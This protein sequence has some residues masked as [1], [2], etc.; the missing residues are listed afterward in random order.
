MATLETML[1]VDEPHLKLSKMNIAESRVKF[2]SGFDKLCTWLSPS[3]STLELDLRHNG[4]AIY[5]SFYDRILRRKKKRKVALIQPGAH[6]DDWLASV[7]VH[8]CT[9]F[10]AIITPVLQVF[11]NGTWL[12]IK[13]MAIFILHHTSLCTV[14]DDDWLASVDVHNC[15][16]F[17]AIITPVLQVFRNGTWFCIKCMAIFILHHTYYLWKPNGHLASHPVS[18]TS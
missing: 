9:W 16:W 6:D 5:V 12:C 8:N 1:Q 10:I 15:T 17:I 7:D 18:V 2:A 13:C 4:D 3:L 11:R 14:H